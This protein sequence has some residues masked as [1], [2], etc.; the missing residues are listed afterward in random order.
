MKSFN[1]KTFIVGVGVALSAVFLPGCGGSNSVDDVFSFP[2]FEQGQPNQPAPV[3]SYEVLATY[4]HDTAAYT[5]GLLYANG[6][7]YEST[8]LRGESSLREVDLQSGKVLRK[9]DND[10]NVFAEGLA[11]RAGQLYQLS[12]DTGVALIWNQTTFTKS[13]T[14]SAPNPA[15]GLTHIA[16]TDQFVLSDGTSTLRFLDSN[17]REVASLKV[18]DN[19]QEV[20]RLNELEYVR[21]YIVANLFMTDEIVAINPTTGVVSFRVDLSGIIDKQAHGLTYEDVL[22]GIA[23][24]PDD[25]GLLVT[26][27]RWPNLYHILITE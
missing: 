1:W 25:T 3:F 20:S 22:N 4:P 23:H 12:L 27:K 9:V 24:D 26:G 8:G 5:Q 7:I 15:W 14:V 16:S 2:Q 11:L 13:A 21:G 17:F 10:P 6:R 19:G 18:T